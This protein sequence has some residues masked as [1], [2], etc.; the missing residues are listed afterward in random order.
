MR[1]LALAYFTRREAIMVV[2]LVKTLT[3][4]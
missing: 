4:F 3:V 1:V 2:S